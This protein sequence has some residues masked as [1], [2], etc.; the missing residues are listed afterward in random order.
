MPEH[1]E[2]VSPHR[3]AGHGCSCGA[4][5]I[6][7][8][9]PVDC[10]RLVLSVAALHLVA[11]AWGAPF[12]PPASAGEVADLYRQGRLRQI[13]GVGPGRHGEIGR[14][15]RLAGLI[16]APGHGREESAHGQVCVT[17][18]EGGSPRM[19]QARQV[20]GAPPL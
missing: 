7:R 16:S 1:N 15:L 8:A 4:H 12:G 19:A 17:T 9:C 14:G 3:A 6:T 11:R 2:P 18:A 5:Q 20:S 13:P 10:L